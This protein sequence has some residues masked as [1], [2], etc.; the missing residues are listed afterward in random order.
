MNEIFRVAVDSTDEFDEFPAKFPLM[1]AIRVIAWIHRSCSTAEL[2]KKPATKA[3]DNRRDQE[4][5]HVL[6][7]TSTVMPK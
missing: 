7:T 1:K 5:A 6:D 2:R 3:T 4:P